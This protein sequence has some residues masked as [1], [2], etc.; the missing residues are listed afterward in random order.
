VR[1]AS[2]NSFVSTSEKTGLVG[3]TKEAINVAAGTTSWN[4]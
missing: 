1:A 3:L 4:S 2:C